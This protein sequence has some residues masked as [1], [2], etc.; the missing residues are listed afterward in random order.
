VASNLIRE[1]LEALEHP[2]PALPQVYQEPPREHERRRERVWMGPDP[3]GSQPALSIDEARALIRQKMTEYLDMPEPDHMLLIALPP[4]SG[5]THEAVRQIERWAMLHPRGRALYAGQRH[6]MWDDLMAASTLP[7]EGRDR[8][9]YHWQPHTAGNPETGQGQTCRYTSQF[10]AWAERGYPGIEFCKKKSVCADY[11]KRCVYL[12]QRERTQP[13]VFVQHADIALGHT[14]LKQATLLI[15]DESPLDAFLHPW[16]IPPRDIVPPSVWDEPEPDVDLIELLRTLRDLVDIPPPKPSGKQPAAWEGAALIERL[17]GAAHVLSVCEGIRITAASRAYTPMLRGPDQ[18]DSVPYWHLGCLKGYLEQEAQ[19][20][21]AG[22]DYV[23][24]VRVDAQGLFLLMRRDVDTLPPHVIWLDA[25]ANPDLYRAIFRDGRRI[26]VVAPQVELSGHVYQLWP[27]L[28]NKDTMIGPD[29]PKVGKKAPKNRQAKREAI[30]QQVGHIIQTRGYTRPAVVTYKDFTS[31]FS[32]YD[33]AHFGG[34]RGTNRLRDCDALLV[35]GTPQAA[36]PTLVD[37]AAM[38]HQERLRPFDTSWSDRD[39]RYGGHPYGYPVSGFWHD[40]TLHALLVQTREAELVQAAH[41]VRPLYRPVDIWLLT[42]LPLAAMP[43]DELLD[44][45]DLFDAPNQVDPYRWHE[46]LR[47]LESAGDEG[48]SADDVRE[49]M[50]IPARTAHR[51]FDA[52]TRQP[53]VI[54]RNRPAK[55]G[56]PTRICVKDF[57]GDFLPRLHV[58]SYRGVAKSRQEKD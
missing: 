22:R 44:L 20:A 41:R 55:A 19:E 57:S 8:W 9:W 17:G 42:N 23:R 11:I 21:L 1:A 14:F 49:Q 28:N 40:A 33:T 39:Q 50:D 29:E 58:Y 12:G 16:L 34:L 38:L 10:R 37:Q 43:P 25:T 30:D 36:I 18:A 56:R 15:G 26:E 53:G 54:V 6:N 4:G 46:L 32:V 2:P 51:W 35:I 13:I 7:T 48:I 3:E 31:Q 52:L 5:K 47:L 24:R 45:R 27:S